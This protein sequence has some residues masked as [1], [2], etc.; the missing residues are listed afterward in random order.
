ME[1]SFDFS[2]PF[3]T[4]PRLGQCQ[5]ARLS[6]GERMLDIQYWYVCYKTDQGSYGWLY[7]HESGD[8]KL[9][10]DWKTYQ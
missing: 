2:N 6:S 1:A 7:I 3:T 5:Q 4:Q 8:G 9:Q 10:F